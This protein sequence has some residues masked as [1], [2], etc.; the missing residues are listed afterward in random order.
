MKIYMVYDSVGVE[1][2]WSDL[3][4]A[5]ERCFEPIDRGTIEPFILSATLDDPYS[6]K[7]VRNTYMYEQVALALPDIIDN[8]SVDSLVPFFEIN[9]N[10]LGI[11]VQRDHIDNQGI[12]TMDSYSYVIFVGRDPDVL[13]DTIKE[14][15]CSSKIEG[16]EFKDKTMSI[17]SEDFNRL[18]KTL[19]PTS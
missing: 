2:V 16:E 12:I 3:R 9:D 18:N 8:L 4:L 1:S 7:Y 13:M 19:A 15:V 6:I 10:K 17:S 11:T 5:Y 14:F